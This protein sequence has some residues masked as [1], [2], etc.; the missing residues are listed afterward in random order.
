MLYDAF[1]Q[2]PISQLFTSLNQY[3]VIMEVKPGFQLGP[4]ALQ[5]I[6][7]RSQTAGMVPL[8]ELVTQQPTVA[9]LSVNHQGQF[10]SVTLSFNLKGN[11]PLG[12][13]VSAIQHADGNTARAADDP[14]QLPGQCAGIPD[15]AVQH[16][17]PDPGGA[18][19]GLYH[20]GNA[21]REH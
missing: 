13:A 19:R 11:A 21:V 12:P 5:R 3:F 18:D 8:S 17:D 20:P 4:N 16:A 10:P 14:G 2:R 7:V 1:G 15:L 6:Y 9:P